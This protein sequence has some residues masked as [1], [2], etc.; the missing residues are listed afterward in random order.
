M[1][2]SRLAI[3]GCLSLLILL[4][5]PVI[6]VSPVAAAH[7][8]HSEGAS[9]PRLTLVSEDPARV[10]LHF[11]L[12]SWELEEVS[13]R[14]HREQA[15]HVPGLTLPNNAGAPNLPGKGQFLAVPNGA[16]VSVRILEAHTE[17]VAGVNLAPAPRIPLESERGPLQASRDE[18]IY[19]RDAFYPASP[20]SLSEVR[21]IRGVP[22]AVLGITPFQYNPVS[23]ELVVYRDLRLEVSFRG[24]DG[25]FGEERLRNRWWEPLLEDL[26]LNYE[27]LESI[28]AI[29]QRRGRETD[30]RAGTRT[31]DYEYIIVCQDSP[32]FVAWA[33]SLRR[34]RNEQGIRTGVVTTA[35]LG[36]NSF[37]AIESYLDE[38]YNTWDIP[39]VAALMLGDYGT[40]S[41]G[42]VCPFYMSYCASD[43]VYADV[44]GDQLP[45]IILARMC[46]ETE[47]NL[48]AM[49]GKTL[50]YEREPPTDP[51]YYEHPMLAAGWADESWYVLCSEIL[52]GYFS[53]VQ[54]RS[55]VREYAIFSGAP[56]TLWSTAPNTNLIVEYF[57]PNGLGYIPST[58]EHLTD[59]G[60]NAERI[61]ADI[62]DG[63]FLSVHR[64]HGIPEGWVA[65]SYRIPDLVGLENE[66]PTFVLSINCKTGMFDPPDP[67][68]TEV[69]H[70]HPHGALGVISASQQ[71]YS[72]VNDTY[73]WGLIDFMWPDFDPGSGAPGTTDARPAFA[74]ASAKYYLEASSWPY[75]PEAK[76]VTYHLFHHHGDAFLTLYTQVPQALT[77]SHDS[78][79]TADSDS[80]VVAA[81]A[82][83]WIGLSLSGEYLA[84]A[85][86]TGAP[87]ALPIPPQTPGT[88]VLVTVTKQ[89][90][91]RYQ[92]SVPVVVPTGIAAGITGLPGEFSLGP[93]RPNPFRGR[94]D[95]QF[96]LPEPA[97][98][99]LSVYDVSGRLV[100]RIL[101]D[102]VRP[103]GTHT[104][105]WNGKD[106]S[107]RVVGAGVYFL[108]LEAGDFTA[109]RRTVFLR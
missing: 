10:E 74:N 22:A 83:S 71:S 41:G 38:A 97:R 106:S 4:G 88:E 89:D 109:A 80:F 39:P 28:A 91:T 76:E 81:D 103:A 43:N 58:P 35:E 27:S 66:Q 67:C 92:R 87:V 7:D 95:I 34:W 105:F 69:I 18:S 98:V 60:G 37:T 75:F 86:G 100:M 13:L 77:V 15:V 29:E 78:V 93:S 94:T 30:L 36:G 46:A 59:W 55:P 44:D 40:G 45:D 50:S 56:D 14:G 12:E 3:V 17:T 64:D 24:G 11:S 107:G 32:S 5:V 63:A 33:D 51:G 42:V 79:L 82:G 85:A 23:R 101:D 73:F 8:L 99:R 20:V 21:K 52:F 2:A 70:R 48:E 62:N 102:E 57:G 1:E 19:S 108:R 54:G 49:I 31:E 16:T 68:F 72:F 96:G 6:G 25:T 47:T 90:H 84:A 9:A 53:I 61:N 26:L 104:A 65:P